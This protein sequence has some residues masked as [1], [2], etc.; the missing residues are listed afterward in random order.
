MDSESGLDEHHVAIPAS[1]SEELRLSLEVYGVD[2]RAKEASTSP[3]LLEAVPE[4]R[5]VKIRFSD[6]DATVAI[7]ATYT[8]A[9]GALKELF[10]KP[11]GEDAPPVTKQVGFRHKLG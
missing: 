2:N 9:L 1:P 3:S 11:K 4:S 8:N 10:T 7:M 5:R 6:V